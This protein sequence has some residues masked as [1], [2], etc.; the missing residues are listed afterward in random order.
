M[1]IVTGEQTGDTALSYSI[2]WR[3]KGIVMPSLL[4]ILSGNADWTRNIE[5]KKVGEQSRDT[6]WNTV[7]GERKVVRDHYNEVTVA[8][9]RKD[10]PRKVLHIIV[11]AYDTGIAFR[12]FFPEHADGGDYLRI[13]GE[14]TTYVMPDGTKG[15]FTPTAQSTY[16]LLSLKISRDSVNVRSRLCC[17][18]V[19][20]S[21]SLK[22]RW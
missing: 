20:M 8:V 22:P 7:Y 3:E 10:N 17:P 5:V 19:S 16:K 6:T 12:Y 21:A 11:R 4:G 13:T 9:V 14:T 1:S 2:E 18:M 15:Y